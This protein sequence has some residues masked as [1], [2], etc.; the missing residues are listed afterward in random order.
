MDL[1][2]AFLEG[3][4]FQM[5]LRGPKGNFRGLEPDLD[6]LLQTFY[7]KLSVPNRIKNLFYMVQIGF[8]GQLKS[9]PKDNLIGKITHNILK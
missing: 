9:G 1:T 7:H 4:E 3:N 6:V 2:L 5:E 8:Q